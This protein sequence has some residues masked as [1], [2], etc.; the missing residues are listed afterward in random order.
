MKT[1][2]WEVDLADGD[3]RPVDD[4]S[5]LPYVHW[6]ACDDRPSRVYDSDR[7]RALH[8]AEKLLVEAIGVSDRGLKRL[9]AALKRVRNPLTEEERQAERRATYLEVKR[10]LEG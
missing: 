4:V 2:G 9:R 3:V 7:S 1:P 8:R 6:P 5:Q 10:Y